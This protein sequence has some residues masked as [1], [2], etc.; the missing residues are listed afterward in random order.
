M[1]TPRPFQ[2][3]DAWGPFFEVAQMRMFRLLSVLLVP[4]VA[5]A[6]VRQPPRRPAPA[7]KPA[8]APAPKPVASPTP[9]IPLARITGEVFDSVAVAPLVEATVQ[10]VEAE[11][12]QNVRSIRTD[13]IGLFVLDSMRVG[14]YLVGIIHEQVDRLGLENRIIQVNIEGSGDV[15]LSL[16][17]PAPES[18]LSQACGPTGA[19]QNRGAFMGVVRTAR[20][21]PLEGNARVRVQ[22]L[23]TIVTSSGVSRRFP[24]RFADAQPN[25]RFLM[26]GVPPEGTITTRAYAGTDSSGVVEL[27]VPR[28]G[29]LVRDIIIANPVRVAVTPTSPTERPRTLLKGTSR[30]RGVVRDTMG[31]PLVGAR[32]SV[33]GTGVEGTSTNG[34][35]FLFEGLPGGSWMVEARAVGFEP[36][37]V[38][39]DFIDGSESLAELRLDGIAPRLDTVRVQADRWSREMAAFEERKKQ[40]GGYFIDDEQLN[41]RNALFVADIMR[42][43]PGVTVSPGGQGGR[44]R[45]LMRGSAGAGSCVPAVFLNGMNTPVPDGVLDNLVSSAEVRGVEVYTRTGSTPPQFQSRNGCGSIV[46]WTGQRRQR[47]DR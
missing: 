16:G 10:F 41:K 9:K 38:A 39:V 7:P 40:G 42:A 25:G 15:S 6:Q 4:A 37:R 43:T 17:L 5:G 33:P 30:V 35:A 23:E 32:I 46:I 8:T 27:P 47:T 13:S 2:P 29:L 19:G 14:T 12:P 21:A 24:S 22:Y 31:S 11:N 1:V 20:G 3:L 28:H 18:I 34:G 45:V 26:C 36:K 44:D